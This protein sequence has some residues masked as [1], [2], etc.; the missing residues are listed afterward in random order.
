MGAGRPD[1]HVRAAREPDLPALTDVYNHYVRTSAATFDIEPLTVEQRRDWLVAHPDTGPHRL[2]VATEGDR[3]L[4]Y[5]SSGPFRVRPAYRSTV[6]T[7]VYL[8]L[9]A[10]ARGIGTLLYERLFDELGG[11]GLHRAVAGVTLP[12]EQSRALHRRLGFTEVGTFTEV[13]FKFDR[14]WDVLWLEKPL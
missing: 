11:Q 2:L 12:N 10:T 3:I 9:G 14:Y 4:G 8:D 6:E 7:S 5:A 1:V 13:G